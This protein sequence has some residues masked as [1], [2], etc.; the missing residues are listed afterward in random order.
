MISINK[1]FFYSFVFSI[2]FHLLFFLSFSI[3]V[4]KSSSPVIF[5]FQD[6]IKKD[7][8][9][10]VKEYK[11]ILDFLIYK[12]NFEIDYSFLDISKKILFIFQYN[13]DYKKRLFEEKDKY[14]K[15]D[16]Y[17]VFNPELLSN[18]KEE[19]S[20]FKIFMSPYGRVI[21]SFPERLLLDSNKTIIFENYIKKYI[22]SVKDKFFWTKLERMIK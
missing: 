13:P 21:I 4:N 15:T 9:F 16:D 19:N 14:I 5:S 8:L 2:F 1:F 6:I 7:D 10:Y 11:D 22:F 17:L 12:R 18:L 3:Y 20:S